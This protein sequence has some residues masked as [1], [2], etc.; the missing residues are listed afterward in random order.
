MLI[1]SCNSNVG[2]DVFKAGVPT[3]EGVAVSCG[4]SGSG[5][6]FAVLNCLS[7]KDCAVVVNEGYCVAVDSGSVSS[8]DSGVC[9]NFAEVSVPT[10]EGVGVLSIPVSCG[11]SRS[12][13]R[14]AVLNCLCIKHC[15]VVVNKGYCVAVDG[16]RVSRSDSGVCSNFAEVSVPTCEG[17]GVLSIPVSCGVS[18]SGSRFAVLNCLCI[19]HCAVVV[20][21]GYCVAVDGGRVSRSDSG[22]CS[23]FAEVSV[24]T[25]E[26]VG[27][28]SIPV[29]CGVS[30]SSCGASFDNSLSVKDCAVV[31]NE[32][33]GVGSLCG[34]CFSG[35]VENNQPLCACVEVECVCTA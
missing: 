17:V 4:V 1:G 20:N 28:L 12:G 32:C 30:R 26:G 33:N 13:S 18:R 14:F 24:P 15:A 35:S 19:N 31:V 27:V 16:G 29:S 22:V 10:C 3:C 2:S 9:S 21:E 8:C 6:R 25:C 7:V 34:V 23:N 11:V 5:S